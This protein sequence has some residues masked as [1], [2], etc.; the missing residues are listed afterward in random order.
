M[1]VYT[2]FARV[3]VGDMCTILKSYFRRDRRVVGADDA[4]K[5]PQGAESLVSASEGEPSRTSRFA[6][7][8]A[9]LRF[10]LV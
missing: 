8:E 9:I 5:E 4:Q 3:R 7:A 2:G 6:P 1:R 10:T